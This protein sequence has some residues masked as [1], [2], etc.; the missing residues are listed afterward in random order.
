[1]QATNFLDNI[2][3]SGALYVNISIIGGMCMGKQAMIVNKNEAVL[4]RLG[5]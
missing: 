2:R 5:I 1:M 4:S 3:N